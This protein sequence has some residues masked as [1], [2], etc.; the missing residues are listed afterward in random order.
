LKLDI[1]LFQLFLGI[2]DLALQHLEFEL[3]Y[4]HLLDDG[5]SIFCEGFNGIVSRVH[6]LL[7][8][9]LLGGV[10]GETLFELLRV[11]SGFGLFVLEGLTEG[12]VLVEVDREREGT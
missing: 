5:I 6:F 11:F 4:L 3:E 10:G 9:H 8:C 2:L 1:G 7:E 12:S